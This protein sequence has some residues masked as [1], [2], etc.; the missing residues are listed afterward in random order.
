MN[1]ARHLDPATDE[2][3]GSR[4][5]RVVGEASDQAARARAGFAEADRQ[6][7]EFV[8]ERPLTALLGAIVAGYLAA[9]ITRIA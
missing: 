3:P 6:L 7:R 1:P 4:A 5:A 2:R 8:H 9:R